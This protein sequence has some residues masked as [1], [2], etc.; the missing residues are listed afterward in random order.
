VSL[1]LQIETHSPLA[2]AKGVQS[3]TPGS[4]QLPWPSQVRGVFSSTPEHEDEPHTVM[5]AGYFAQPPTPLQ[6]PVRPQVVRSLA[7]HAGSGNCAGINV[8]L[9]HDPVWLHDSQGSLHA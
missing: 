7:M 8:H 1:F 4:R 9:P 6:S 5:S 3:R 2:Q